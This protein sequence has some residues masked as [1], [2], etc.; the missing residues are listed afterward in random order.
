MT[1][2][3]KILPHRIPVA[4]AAFA[5]FVALTS[6][7]LAG[8]PAPPPGAPAGSAAQSPVPPAAPT[9]PTSPVELEKTVIEDTADQSSILPTQPT[10]AVGGLDTAFQDV[11]RSLSEVTPAQ[12]QNDVLQSYNDFEKYS[13]S[14]TANTGAITNYGSPTIRGALSDVYQ[15]GIETM[16]RQSNEHPFDINAYESADVVAGPASVIFGPSARTSGYVDF[17][18]KEPYTDGQHTTINVTLGQWVSGGA[19]YHQVSNEQVDTGGPVNGDLAY[20]VSLEEENSSSYYQYAY[21]RYQDL[22][23]A[24]NWHPKSGVVVDWN[25]DYSYYTYNLPGGYNRVTQSLIDSGTYLSGAPTPIIKVGTTYYSPVYNNGFSGLKGTFITRTPGAIVNGAFVPG[26]K[27]NN[28]YTTYEPGKAY[29][30]SAT[31]YGTVVGWVLGPNSAPV[32]VK[33]YQGLTN[34]QNDPLITKEF[35]TQLRETKDISA[36]AS[37]QNNTYYEFFF[38]DSA[39]NGGTYNWIN[40]NL[41]EDRLEFRKKGEFRLFGLDIAHDSNTGASF[42][43]EQVLNYKDTDPSAYT[44]G[45]DQFD[46]TGNPADITRNYLFGTTVY[47]L[48]YANRNV[49]S[50]LYGPI[51]IPNPSVPNPYDAG[52]SVTPGGGASGLSTTTNHTWTQNYGLYSEH[53]FAIGQHWIYDLGGRLTGVFTKLADPLVDPTDPTSVAA[54]VVDHISALIPSVETSLSY[55]P[56]SRVTFYDTYDYVQARNG[57]TTGSPTWASGVNDLSAKAYHSV[58]EL[59]EE[60]AKTEI[61]PNTLFCTADYYHQTR[62]QSIATVSG[63]AVLGRALYRGFET[64][65][66]YRPTKALSIGANYSYISA[67]YLNVAVAT[68]SIV[69]DNATVFQPGVTLPIADYLIPEVPH[70]NFTLFANYQLESGFGL[71][72]SVTAHSWSIYNYT[73]PGTF[74]YLPGKYEGNL[75]LYY[76]R[77]HWKVS[78]DLQNL[79]S[80]RD[81]AGNLPLQPLS[82]QLRFTVRL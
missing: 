26:A 66:R 11:P 51:A 79:T 55:K 70:Q 14:I 18:T 25:A 28:A 77:P 8:D 78:L 9:S 63:N 33:P 46:L 1:M 47:P 71:S 57:M 39:T 50:P 42:R 74:N 56:V 3:T 4:L 52:Y 80:Q 61:I 32:Q 41:V 65:L 34:S 58:S 20:R 6:H 2:N 40:D 49:V 36:D 45:G 54:D 38:N 64:S 44:A 81:F 12:L 13:P 29:T 5:A 73:G 53:S 72:P 23:A 43:F 60:G 15:D 17:Q 48:A 31:A 59:F 35:Q 68:E 16:A 37:I 22:Y 76:N 62:D 24:L 69:A 7:G 67:N 10:E 82:I 27:F 30:P 75:T 19:G 21:D